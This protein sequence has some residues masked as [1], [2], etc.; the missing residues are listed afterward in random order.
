MLASRDISRHK[1]CCY[2]AMPPPTVVR[3][4]SVTLVVVTLVVGALAEPRKPPASSFVTVNGAR[5]EY[6]DWGGDGP[7]LLFLAGLGGTAHV[8]ND[9]APELASKYHCFG[10]TRRGF[11]KSEQTSDGYELDNLVLDIVSFGRSLGLRNITLVGHSYGGTEAV[12]AS[13]L[14]PQL[15][16]RVILLDTAYDPIPSAAPPAEAK[17]FAAV[18]RMTD[19]QRMSSLG[20]YRDYEKRLLGNLW[21]DGLEADLRETVI[22]GKDGSISGRTP[23]RIS[24]AIVSERAAGKWHI[25]QIPVP[26]LLIFANHPWTDYLP[27]L[28]LDEETTAEIVKAGSELEDARRSQIEA[29]RRDSPLARIVELA[30]TDHHCFIQRPKRIVEDMRKFL[31]D[32]SGPAKTSR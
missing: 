29:F 23:A 19:E 2:R 1:N 9:L 5:L 3:R 14:Y 32:S 17:L 26:A 20:S 24:R 15:I 13:E 30:H 11:G 16:R 28:Q 31:A 7:P 21:S 22:V 27:G 18:T 8:F 6:L 12:R 25:T 10:L 4:S